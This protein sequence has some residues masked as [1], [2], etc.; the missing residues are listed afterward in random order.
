MDQGFARSFFRI[1]ILVVTVLGNGIA[2]QTAVDIQSETIENETEAIRLGALWQLDPTRTAVGLFESAA[3]DWERLRNPKRAIFCLNQI[4]KLPRVDSKDDSALRA[5]RRAL[6]LAGTHN[7]TDERIISLSLYSLIYH[8]RGEKDRFHEFSQ[9]S[10][11]LSSGESSDEA[12][13]Y[14]S[15]SAGMYEYYHGKLARATAFFETANDLAQKTDNFTLQSQALSFVSFS[16][17]REG[18]PT[19]AVDKLDFALRQSTQAGYRKGIAL[20][21]FAM[22]VLNYHLSDRQKALEFFATAES[23]FPS[24]FEWKEKA[25]AFNIIGTIYQEFGE[26]NLAE[27]KFQQAFDNYEKSDYVLGK[28]AALTNLAD[29]KLAKSHFGEAKKIYEEAMR[30]SLALDDKFRLAN[31]TEGLGSVAFA[32]RN[33]DAAIAEFKRT[34]QIYNDLG[35][36]MPHIENLLG[37]CYEEMGSTS[38]ARQNYEN[39][40]LRNRETK[41]HIQ[42]SENLFNLASLDSRGDELQVATERVS[43]SIHLARRP[44][45]EGKQRNSKTF[46]FFQLA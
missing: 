40:A 17:M 8:E 31:V 39:A 21:Y 4:A 29:T 10:I 9:L 43:E 37:R 44:L 5:L 30:L 3:Q 27:T 11:S 36:K 6:R 38:K 46:V 45:L 28:T 22:A 20:S 23:L 2:A 25:R 1:A 14:A 33:Y 42:L 41:D 13:A 26:L 15:F 7:L 32:E 18:R 34:L 24:D 19:L 35:V 12:R 16:Y